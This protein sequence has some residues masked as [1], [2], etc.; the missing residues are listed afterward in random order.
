MFGVC[1]ER[2]VTV[3][4]ACGWL[5]CVRMSPPPLNHTGSRSDSRPNATPGAGEVLRACKDSVAGLRAT[6]ADRHSPRG[7]GDDA[8]GDG[9]GG[10]WRSPKRLQH[11]HH[12]AAAARAAGGGGGEESDN[13]DEHLQRLRAERDANLKAHSKRRSIRRGERSIR[14]SFSIR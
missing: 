10:A 6:T 7:S 1:C 2:E 11:G 14:R 4:V 8:A 13:D 12:Q 9:R 5:V 3:T